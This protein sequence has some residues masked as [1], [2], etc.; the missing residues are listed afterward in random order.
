[1]YFLIFSYQP[2]FSR[3]LKIAEDVSLDT[4]IITTRI[5]SIYTTGIVTSFPNI[6]AVPWSKFSSVDACK[7]AIIIFLADAKCKLD[8]AKRL[9]NIDSIV[10]CNRPTPLTSESKQKE[11]WN[12]EL[13]NFFCKIPQIMVYTIKSKL[14]AVLFIESN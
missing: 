5:Y 2:T 3:I 8:S 6:G 14:R 11:L 10:H 1:M 7:R 9:I 13:S 4:S 12:S